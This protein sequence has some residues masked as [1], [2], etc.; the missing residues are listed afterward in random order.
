MLLVPWKW[1]ISTNIVSLL[2][3]CYC[4][5]GFELIHFKG[6]QLSTL[7]LHPSEKGSTLKWKNLLLFRIGEWESKQEVTSNLSCQKWYPFTLLSI[8]VKLQWLERWWLIYSGWFECICKSLESSLNSSAAGENNN[9][10]YF[11]EFFLIYCENACCMSSFPSRHTT[12]KQCRFN[13]NSMSLH[14]INIESTLFQGCV[15]AGLNCLRGNSNEYT[16]HMIL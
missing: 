10:G 12:L 14:W 1:Q 3:F 4:H 7:L 9:Q 5:G 11:R 8:I 2:Q 13:V 16:Q 6:K 15:S